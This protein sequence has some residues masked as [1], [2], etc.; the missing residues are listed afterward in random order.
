MRPQRLDVVDLPIA[1][2]GRRIGRRR[3]LTGATQVEEHKPAMCRQPAEVTE[4]SR[5][6]HRPARKAEQRRSLTDL[7]IGEPSS[8]RGVEGRHPA[9]IGGRHY[10][11][12]TSSSPTVVRRSSTWAQTSQLI[13]S[14]STEVTRPRQI[15]VSPTYAGA[16]CR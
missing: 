1:P 9:I 8:V 2:I 14:P 12:M 6:L 15:R 10:V 4:I 13:R 7:V 5:A 3:R 11:A 16:T